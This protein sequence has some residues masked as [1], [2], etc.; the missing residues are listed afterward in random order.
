MGYVPSA[1]VFLV[2]FPVFL[3]GSA[4]LL[5]NVLG[6]RTFSTSRTTVFDAQRGTYRIRNG[7]QHGC[8]SEKL[9]QTLLQTIAVTDIAVPKI[10]RKR[11]PVTP[12]RIVTPDVARR[13]SY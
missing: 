6:G 12:T 13:E 2:R 8:C 11:I 4:S 10:L 3:D 9:A 1:P 5:T 7:V